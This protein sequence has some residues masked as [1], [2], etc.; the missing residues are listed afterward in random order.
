MQQKK[1]PTKTNEAEEQFHTSQHGKQ[2]RA[3]YSKKRWLPR[4]QFAG[5]FADAKMTYNFVDLTND[6]FIYMTFSFVVFL[7]GQHSI[8]KFEYR[9]IKTDKNRHCVTV[10]DFAHSVF[11]NHCLYCLPKHTTSYKILLLINIRIV[12]IGSFLFAKKLR[13]ILVIYTNT[14]YT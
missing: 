8:E 14:K 2:N 11:F 5:F 1:L 10:I 7:W 3:E 4:R 12:G 6:R 13:N 9:S